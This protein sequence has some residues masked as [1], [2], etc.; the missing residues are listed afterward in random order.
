[1]EA[2]GQSKLHS[3]QSQRPTRN[4][5]QVSWPG[6]GYPEGGGDG[7]RC[8]TRDPTYFSHSDPRKPT[9]HRVSWVEDPLKPEVHHTG[10]EVHHLGPDTHHLEVAEYRPGAEVPFPR[11]ALV[12][13]VEEQEEV[14]SDKH[15]DGEEGREDLL[16]D[17]IRALARARSSY[18]A[19]QYRCLRARLT[20]NSGNP[21]RPGDPA[22]ELLQDIRQLLTDL[23]NYLAKDPDIRAVFGSREPRVPGDED[24]GN[25]NWRETSQGFGDAMTRSSMCSHPT[26]HSPRANTPLLHITT[27][28]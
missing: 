22:T 20:S 18:V 1:M 2:G 21:Y 4:T 15:K 14:G 10:Q 17:H 16:T 8:I 3:K 5:V 25:E 13:V 27:A 26:S 23:Q 6:P 7:C 9:P 28:S 12:S 11:P 19:R 24:L